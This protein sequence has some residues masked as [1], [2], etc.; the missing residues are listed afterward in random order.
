MFRLRDSREAVGVWFL[1]VLLTV[2]AIPGAAALPDV[3]PSTAE[4]SVNNV[5]VDVPLHQVLR[6]IAMQ[7]GVTIGVD[8][9]VPDTLISLEANE[10]PLDE[11]LRRVAAGQGL[12]I[13]QVDPAGGLYVVGT[14]KPG[15]PSFFEL[16]ESK[17]IYLRYVTAKHVRDSLPREL[18][19]YVSSGERST[20]VLVF[21]PPDYATRILQ[22]VDNL[23]V[24][25]RQIVLEALVVELSQ[26]AGSE[27][28]IDWEVSG[29]DSRLVLA[30]TPDVFEGLLR[31]TSVNERAFSLLQV[32]LRTLVKEGSAAIRSRPRVATLNGE[33]A[34]MNVTREEYFTILT[35]IN[36]ELLR[37][38]LQV[39]RSGVILEMTPQVGENGDITVHIST[40]VSE[41]TSRPGDVSGDN[42]VQGTLPVVRRRTAE[43]RVR[44]KDGDAIVIGGL[45]ESVN[46]DEV[47]RVPLLGSIPLLGYLFRSTKSVTEEKEV[48]IFITPRLIE[49]GESP[50]SETHS[51]INVDKELTGLK[52]EDSPEGLDPAGSDLRR[53]GV[54]EPIASGAAPERDE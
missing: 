29:R 54:A 38:E 1:I 36:G 27:L 14:G 30:Q 42:G 35:D 11:C 23:D 40:E 34:T 9:S 7:A 21:A 13:R 15:T 19:P 22:M 41:V 24:P 26:E 20:E 6:D 44:V 10:L 31:L 52:R 48:V 32:K 39:I 12:V 8:P 53:K 16:A 33:K 47:K 51:L 45:I 28:G 17:R 2:L 18:Q 37:T 25:P 49:D 46:R 50:L 3:P 5:W 4:R 43:T